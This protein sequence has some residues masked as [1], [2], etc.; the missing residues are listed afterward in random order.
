MKRIP[1]RG[2]LGRGKYVLVDDKHYD[3]LSKHPWHTSKSGNLLYAVTNIN[4]GIKK[5]DGRWKFYT[6]KMHNLILPKVE[7]YV[8]D[9]IDGNGL[10]NQEGNLRYATRAQNKQNSE[11]HKIGGSRYKLVG[12]I[13]MA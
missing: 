1:L 4:T 2:S 10:N 13:V 3:L 11:K 7:G 12:K 9:H 5:L 8:T 6:L